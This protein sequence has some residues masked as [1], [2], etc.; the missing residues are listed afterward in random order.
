MSPG[1][2]DYTLGLGQGE[3]SDET[4]DAKEIAGIKDKQSG[5]SPMRDYLLSN[6]RKY[7]AE[8]QRDG[9]LVVYVC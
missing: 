9:N 7:T 5:G 1:D 3:V 4:F 6:N 2:R 8:F